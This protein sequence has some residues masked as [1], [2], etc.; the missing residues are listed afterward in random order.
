MTS[1]PLAWRTD[2][3]APGL[4]VLFI[5]FNPS[6]ASYARQANYAG[7]NNRFYRVLYLAGITPVLHVPEDS[8]RFVELYRFGFTNLSPRPT[9]R[10]DEL[11]AE[12]MRSGAHRIRL[13]LRELQP[14]IACYVG[15]GVYQKVAQSTRPVPWGFREG[16]SVVP[17]VLD[18]VGP[19]TSGLVRMRLDEMVDIYRALGNHL[20][21]QL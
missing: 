9:A 18:F 16:A 3:L 8:R 13:L 15:K 2:V 11:T 19:S 5:G 6:P 7:R 14:H 17:G 21:E 20:K 10:A 12:E 1:E 4:R